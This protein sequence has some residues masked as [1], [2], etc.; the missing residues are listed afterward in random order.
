[1]HAQVYNLLFF[2]S[3]QQP[4]PLQHYGESPNARFQIDLSLPLTLGV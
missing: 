2:P 1:M 4:Q 3:T